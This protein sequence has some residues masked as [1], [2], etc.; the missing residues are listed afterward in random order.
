MDKNQAIGIGAMVTIVAV[1]MIFFR[2]DPPV[3][4]KATQNT[5]QVDTAATQTAAIPSQPSST[6]IQTPD[7]AAQANFDAASIAQFGIFAGAASGEEQII[8]LENDLIKAELTTKGGMFHLATLQDGYKT[9]WEDADIKLWDPEISKMNVN[10]MQIGVGTMNTTDLYFNADKSSAQATSGSPARIVMT[11]PSTDRSKYIEFVYTLNEGEYDVDCQMNIVG[12]GG[13]IDGA[14]NPIKFNWLASSFHIE[15]GIDIERQHSSVFWRYEGMSRDYQNEASADD[16]DELEQET[17]WMC[18]KQNFFSAMV[19]SEDGFKPGGLIKTVTPEETDTI[20][21]KHYEAELW[22][23]SNTSNNMRFYFGPNDFKILKDLEVEEAERVIDYGWTIFGWVNRNLIRPV[24]NWLCSWIPSYGLVIIILTLLIKSLLFPITWKNYLSSAK[25]RVLKPEIEELNK[26][27]EG[28]EASEK[29]AAT[30]ALYRQTGVNPL[31]GCLPMLLQLPILYAMFRFF[32]ASIELRGQSFLWA[33]DLGTFDEIFS[34]TAD[35]GLISDFYGNH[36]SGF[37]VLMAISTFFYTRM[38]SAN[39]PTQSQPGMPNMKVIMNFFPLMM[40]VFFNKFSAGL[41][42]YYFIANF[43][44][45]G[46]MLSIK[47]FFINEDKI[48]S[49]IED[50]KAKPKKKSAFQERLQEMQKT[51]AAEK[52]KKKK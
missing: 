26:K 34:W 7:S 40:L 5:E 42:F 52:K 13:I 29:Q 2:P 28:K 25:M 14:S 45:I 44:S 30:M 9:Y 51:Q 43:I 19:I 49:K 36:V 11:L 46:Q 24:F 15:K 31:A 47:K 10:L 35:L 23:A 32:P 38:S 4:D 16:F 37:T 3:Q 22:L 50:N 39:M 27:Y 48:R 8:V 12:L 20:H 6:I 41:S 33:D 21:N 18:F 1:W 17:N